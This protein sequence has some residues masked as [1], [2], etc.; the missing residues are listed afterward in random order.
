MIR[1]HCGM[2]MLTVADQPLYFARVCTRCGVVV[3]Q[4]KRLPK[5]MRPLCDGCHV[6]LTDADWEAR[7]CTQC[8]TPFGHSPDWRTRA[9][10]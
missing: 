4:R 8:H 7:H 1:T 5:K 9:R 6:E 3:A 2:P 10:S